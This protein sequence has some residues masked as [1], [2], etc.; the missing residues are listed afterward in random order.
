M[1]ILKVFKNFLKSNF[2]KNLNVLNEKI[3]YSKNSIN[4]DA[5][6]YFQYLCDKIVSA[7]TYFDKFN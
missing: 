1:V 6:Y 2:L 5:P 4:H 7:R 3:E